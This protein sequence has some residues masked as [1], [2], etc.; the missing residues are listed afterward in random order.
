M[1]SSALKS[2]RLRLLGVLISLHPLGSQRFESSTHADRCKCTV[3]YLFD[4]IVAKAWD[5]LSL[6]KDLQSNSF[7]EPVSESSN[8]ALLFLAITLPYVGGLLFA[9]TS[10]CLLCQMNSRSTY[11]ISVQSFLNESWLFNISSYFLARDLSSDLIRL[12]LL[13]SSLVP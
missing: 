12:G 8:Q 5:S 11:D 4:D 1:H 6:L 9:M 7:S 3:T 13:P 2:R 10:P